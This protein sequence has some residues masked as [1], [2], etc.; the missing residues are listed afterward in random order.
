MAVAGCAQEE[1]RVAFFLWL[2]WESSSALLCTLRRLWDGCHTPGLASSSDVQG[3]DLPPTCNVTLAVV[4]LLCL[5]FLVP[6]ATT[7]WAHLKRVGVG[8]EGLN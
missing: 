3:R 8:V 2:G 4:A 6:S 7:A 5:S 1:G